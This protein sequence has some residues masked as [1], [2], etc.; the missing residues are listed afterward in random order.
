MALQKADGE[1][2]RVSHVDVEQ[3]RIF[4]E[5]YRNALVR[6]NLTEFDNVI[7]DSI[8]SAKLDEVLSGKVDAD[9]TRLALMKAGYLA[10][11]NEPPYNNADKNNQ[12][13]DA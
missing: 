9:T 6:R 8:Y 10:L 2:V 7:Q 13:S 1:Y 3:N 11:K 4:I 12:W 5:R